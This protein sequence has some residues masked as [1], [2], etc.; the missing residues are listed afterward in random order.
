MEAL[1]QMV[2]ITAAFSMMHERVLELL[3]LPREALK[4][5]WAWAGNALDGLT[6]GSFNWVSGVVLAVLTRAD[7][8]NALSSTP[9]AFVNQYLNWGTSWSWRHFMGCVLMGCSTTLGS[10][11][12]HDTLNGLVDFR[13]QLKG[14]PAD[15]QK[16][17][18]DEV[19]KRLRDVARQMNAAT[20]GTAGG[21][22]ISN[23]TNVSFANALLDAVTRTSP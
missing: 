13:K 1:I 11:F 18:G 2:A 15:A 3:R 8:L 21:E 6:V 20:P 14:V 4:C 5:R 12:W 9:D 17:I 10:R 22:A 23:A 7:L 16:L 19:G